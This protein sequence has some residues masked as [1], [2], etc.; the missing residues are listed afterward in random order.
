[1]MANFILA[2]EK[3][4]TLLVMKEKAS[5]AARLIRRHSLSMTA[6]GKTM[7]VSAN[8]RGL[9]RWAN[10]LGLL[11]LMTVAM[12]DVE[13]SPKLRR[14]QPMMMQCLRGSDWGRKDGMSNGKVM[15]AS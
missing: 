2:I 15:T 3:T 5:P 11:G 6:V 7:T 8:T 9:K 12:K 10:A 13:H 4:M 1:M 14:I